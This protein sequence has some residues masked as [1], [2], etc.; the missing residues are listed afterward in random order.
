LYFQALLALALS[1]QQGKSSGWWAL[2]KP[3]QGYIMPWRDKTTPAG[4]SPA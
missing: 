3:A 4:R 2:T 1:G